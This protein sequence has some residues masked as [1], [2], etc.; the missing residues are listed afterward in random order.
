MLSLI[1]S[2]NLCF[3]EALYE[4]IGYRS[5]GA[6]ANGFGRSKRIL[7]LLMWRAHAKA[8]GAVE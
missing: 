5:S 1:T 7:F 2:H 3:V 6:V 4:S 8:I